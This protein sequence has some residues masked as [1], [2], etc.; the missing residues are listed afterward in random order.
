MLGNLLSNAVKFT[1]RGQVTLRV[2]A[3]ADEPGRRREDRSLVFSVTDTGIGIA[4]ENLAVIFGAFQQGDGTL[5][6][7]YGGTGLGLSIA[8]EVSAL[9]GGEITATSDLGRGSTFAA[10]PAS[11][12]VIPP[13]GPGPTPP[14][15][16][17]RP[18]AVEAPT[19]S[20]GHESPAAR[21][22]M[23]DSP[24]DDAI[25]AS[26][27]AERRRPRSRRA[28][29][30]PPQAGPAVTAVAGPAGRG[31]RP[32]R[33]VLVFEGTQRRPADAARLQR[34]LR[35]RRHQHRRAGAVATA[36][37]P[38]QGIAL[39]AAEPLPC[40]VARSRRCRPSFDFL[41]QV[42]GEAGTAGRPGPRPQP[43]ARRTRA[44]AGRLAALRFGYPTL[45]LLPSLDELRE[46]ITLHLSAAQP[47]HVPALLGDTRGRPAAARRTSTRTT[48]AASTCW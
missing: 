48:C 23:A 14:S 13:F 12:P 2:P 5:S 31:V 8:S 7:R 22:A 35:P 25:R 30:A 24:R 46:R 10:V 11:L 32:D 38:E 37:R 40:V 41:E 44:S 9:L 20:Q 18:A 29:R 45:E 16:R 1:E 42:A 4:P 21:A 3:A 19:A 28:V 26:G 39:L 33:N 15:P 36:V 43:G 17:D 47:D 27:T 6:R 34:G